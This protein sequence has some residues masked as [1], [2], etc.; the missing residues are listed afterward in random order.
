MTLRSPLQPAV[1]ALCAA[2]FLSLG[3]LPS[4]ACADGGGHEQ[5]KEGF[6]ELSVDAVDKL[7]AA[8]DVSV[9]DNN[10][11]ERFAK[12]HV[13]GAKWL[14]FND[15]QAADLPRDLERKLVFYCANS[16]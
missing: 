15:V 4:A 2:A 7:I 12:S 6:G 10:S 5:K 16:H 1:R 8:K 14:K 3:L 13:P 9:F 11:E